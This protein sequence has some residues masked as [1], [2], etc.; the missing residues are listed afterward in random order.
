LS[1]KEHE[2]AGVEDAGT[3]ASARTAVQDTGS[4]ASASAGVHGT[5]SPASA[6]AGVHGTGSP[7][8]PRTGVGG[9]GSPALPRTGVGGTGSPAL[10]RTGVQDTGSPA[11]ARAGVQGTGS[12]ALPRTGVEGVQKPRQC[13]KRQCGKGARA[14]EDVVSD[15]DGEEDVDEPG[16][17]GLAK[18]TAKR[19]KPFRPHTALG[20]GGVS[21]G[22]M[23][24]N[25]QGPSSFTMSEVVYHK[26]TESDIV[27][28][29]GDDK[30]SGA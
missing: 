27:S 25:K 24:T 15:T 22:S 29:P 7:P 18:G 20:A 30:E 12:P 9:T 19:P 26:C 1:D 14:E 17:P 8:L 3:P 5:G 23:H 13:G 11:S 2:G 4:P 28:N 10:P 21:A 6:R 16:D